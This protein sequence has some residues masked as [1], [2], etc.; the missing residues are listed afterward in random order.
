MVRRALAVLLLLLC[1]CATAPDAGGS[2]DAADTPGSAPPITPPATDR[3]KQADYAMWF[4]MDACV[5]HVAS[6]GDLNKW[7]LERGLNTLEPEVASRI[8]AGETGQ[9]W[10]AGS[11]LGHFFL[12]VVPINPT[13]NKCS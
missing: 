3:E 4:F 12:I 10:S 7:I 1:G 2:A 5:A 9:V 13:V 6:P 8:L 11:P